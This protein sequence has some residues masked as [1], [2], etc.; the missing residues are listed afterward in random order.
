MNFDWHS[1]TEKSFFQNEL[2]SNCRGRK[3]QTTDMVL[4]N[5]E[6]FILI[7]YGHPKDKLEILVCLSNI[8]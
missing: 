2:K 8:L 7:D 6:L 5:Q 1:K 3:K 4:L